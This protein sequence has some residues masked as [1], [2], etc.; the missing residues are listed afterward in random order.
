L[1]LQNWDSLPAE[2][3]EQ[4]GQQSWRDFILQ[5]WDSQSAEIEEQIGQQS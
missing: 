4:I 2:I 5:N 3:E 1:I